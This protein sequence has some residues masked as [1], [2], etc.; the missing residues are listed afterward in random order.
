MRE[1]VLGI[2]SSTQ[3]TKAVMVDL[4]TGEELAEGRAPHSG[5]NQQ[6][7]RDWWSA[8]KMAVAQARSPDYDI[9]GLSVAGQQHGLITLD[10]GGEPVRPAPLWNNLDSAADAVR[11]NDLADFATATGTRL[12][13]S[14]TITKLAHLGRTAPGDLA[15][16]AMVALP[17]DYLNYRL[18]GELVTDRGDA[19]GTGWWSPGQ[20]SMRPDLLALAIG[21]EAALRI[22]FPRVLGPEEPAGVLSERAARELAL[23]AGLPVGPGS[24][25][26]PAAA[27]GAGATDQELVVS[28]GTSGTAYAVSDRPTSD[29]SGEVAG[30]ADATG[31]F[32]PLT[33]MLNCTRVFDTIAG[34][35]SIER[36]EALDRAGAIQPGADG[37]LLM[38]YFEGERTPNL[39]HASGSLLGLTGMTSRPDL[40]LR[41]AI[42][43]V[44]AGLAYCL[45]A[46]ARLG[47]TAPRIT[48]VGGGSRHPTW[49]QAIADAAGLTV[50][51]R[52]GSEHVARGAAIQ[53]AAIVRNERVATLAEAW[54]PESVA[55]RSPTPGARGA[56]QLER[57]RSL[58]EQ[59]RSGDG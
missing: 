49:Q 37:L 52:G 46:L 38:P 10:H 5:G 55:E 53:A 3:S 45:E 21:E 41:A 11:L 50:T 48:L 44:A 39:P 58:I 51:V 47:V 9:R 31:R 27:V 26:N 40:M 22:R 17:H 6:D 32:L 7:P 24:G 25:D 56:F 8:L 12:V 4:E 14:I 34:L 29:P 19:S 57:R 2:D 13:A 42:D 43:G 15:Q 36:I 54:R 35:L 18:T 23:P 30:F 28:L 33:C 20:A 1:V 59:M 16:T